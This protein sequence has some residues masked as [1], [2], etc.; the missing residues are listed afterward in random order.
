MVDLRKRF[1]ISLKPQQSGDYD[2][3]KNNDVLF[4]ITTSPN[5]MFYNF[6]LEEFTGPQALL[7]PFGQTFNAMETH[8]GALK[9]IDDLTV[10]EWLDK[11]RNSE[12]VFAPKPEDDS[13]ERNRLESLQRWYSDARFNLEKKY[14][15]RD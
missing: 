2:V 10:K 15:T 5:L 1:P 7:M 14:F 3:D 6:N 13:T 4:V 8:L 9:T 12:T 11:A